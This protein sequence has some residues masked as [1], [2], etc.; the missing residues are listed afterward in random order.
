MT[1]KT[2]SAHAHH[3]SKPLAVVFATLLL[4]GCVVG[5]EYERPNLFVPTTWT[6]TSGREMLK[7]AE[8]HQWWTKLNDP[9]LTSYVERAIGG[10]LDVAAA[11]A[12]VREA[13]AS[14]RQETG[15]L[16]PSLDSASSLKRT[17]TPATS[18]ATGQADVFTQY[19]SGFDASWELDL[20]GGKQRTVEV[21]RYGLDA[22]QEDLR[23]TMLVLIGDVASNYSQA[24]ASQ[25]R[26]ALARRTAKS[27]RETAALTRVKLE[28]GTA[29]SGDVANAEALAASTE[30][31][32]HTY[33]IARTAAVHRLG[34]LLGQPPSV[35]SAQ[36]SKH[37]PIPRPKFPL[38]VGVP[39][40]TLLVRPDVRMAELRLAQ[41]T[42]RIGAAE[43]A[44]YPSV[45]L[46]GNIATNA[47]DASSFAKAS[48][49]AWAFGPSLT[50]PIFRGGQLAAGVEAA[51]ARR[52]Q[53]FAAYQSSVLTAM[54]DIENAIVSLTQERARSGKLA[55]AASSYRTAAN[56]ARSEFDAGTADYLSLLDTQRAL[57]RA[58]AALIDSQLAVTT[59][60]IALNKALGGGWSGA[61]DT[62]KPLVIDLES[63]PRLRIARQPVVANATNSNE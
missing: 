18:S 8:L 23:N 35:L 37:A 22:A 16:F 61:V 10:N 30:A 2:S 3:L 59:S 54:E 58:E 11:K 28:A 13:R 17:R 42:A 38:P 9:L 36:L 45:S 53:S 39:A 5:P 60:Y 4:S 29:K 15:A 26:L 32:I 44:R 47:M 34:V 33:E 12:R 43:A 57:Y 24:R 55:T 14:L 56:S 31:D 62:A 49:I 40:E 48:T 19:Q 46:T 20:F 27:Q 1:I 63:G 6:N 50:V 25:A 41:A 52:D 21:A 7:P 51:K